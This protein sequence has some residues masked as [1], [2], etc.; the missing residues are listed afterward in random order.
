MILDTNT[1]LAHW[2]KVGTQSEIRVEPSGHTSL[3]ICEFN[4]KGWKDPRNHMSTEAYAQLPQSYRSE[5]PRAERLASS[6][7]DGETGSHGPLRI[8]H[9]ELWSELRDPFCGVLSAVGYDF[10]VQGRVDVR[11]IQEGTGD[12]SCFP[13]YLLESGISVELWN[14]GP[15]GEHRILDLT[16][17]ESYAA[18]IREYIPSDVTSALVWIVYKPSDAYHDDDDDVTEGTPFAHPVVHH[19]SVKAFSQST[20]TQPRQ[21]KVRMQT[22]G[23]FPQ[24]ILQGASTPSGRGARVSFPP[25]LDPTHP[26][27]SSRR[28]LGVTTRCWARV[29]RGSPMQPRREQRPS[30]R[31]ALLRRELSPWEGPAR[32]RRWATV[33]RKLIMVLYSFHYKNSVMAALG[34]RAYKTIFGTLRQ[35]QIADAEEK[36]MTVT[37]I[38]DGQ[39]MG[40]ELP[41]SKTEKF[42][43]PGASRQD[44]LLCQHPPLH[45]R[46]GANKTAK[47]FTC[48]DCTMRWERTPIPVQ[49]EFPQSTDLMLF[50]RHQ[51]LTYHTVVSRHPKYSNWCRK[52][53]QEA[54]ITQEPCSRQL[55]RFVQYLELATAAQNPV[56]QDSSDGEFEDIRD[57]N[58]PLLNPDRESWTIPTDRHSWT[59]RQMEAE[60]RGLQWAA[61]RAAERTADSSMGY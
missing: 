26:C 22:V 47:W 39:I 14:V 32:I 44:P 24:G 25:G 10:P 27:G 2:K 49:S 35:N 53:K 17:E 5:N 56:P 37:R 9:D 38:L 33:T 52:T 19:V 31:L 18:L 16:P 11:C 29:R 34:E 3:N 60:L 8:N 6:V 43:A 59:P 36:K 41:M 20:R 12:P 54:S 51:C 23:P 45:I 15:A 58:S 13:T 57:P 28:A 4:P 48:L 21:L 55:S 30:S 40:K 61:E 1:N 46:Q 7:T 50:G 42:S